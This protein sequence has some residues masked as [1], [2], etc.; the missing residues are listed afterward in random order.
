MEIGVNGD[1]GGRDDAGEGWQSFRRLSAVLASLLGH[2]SRRVDHVDA[3]T[4]GSEGVEP[5]TT[6][7]VVP[8]GQRRVDDAV[9]ERP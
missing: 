2:L 8:G 5:E 6:A 7:R 9:G 3:E 1:D 4:H